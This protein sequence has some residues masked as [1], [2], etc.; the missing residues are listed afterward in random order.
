MWRRYLSI[1]YRVRIPQKKKTLRHETEQNK[2]KSK[3]LNKIRNLRLL[4][5]HETIFCLK[6][7]LSKDTKKYFFLIFSTLKFSILSFISHLISLYTRISSLSYLFLYSRLFLFS[8]LSLFTL[9]SLSPLPFSLIVLYPL[10]LST[11]SLSSLSTFSYLPPISFYTYAL[12]KFISYT[13]II[14][15]IIV[16]EIVVTLVHI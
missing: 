2:T 9:A 14:K 3:K 4:Q 12:Q 11:L 10:Y 7:N 6:C 8:V 1:R 5:N 16:Q 13:S 15:Y